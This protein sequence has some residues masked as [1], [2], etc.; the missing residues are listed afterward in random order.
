MIATIT[1]AFASLCISASTLADI[2]LANRYTNV[3]QL[4]LPLKCSLKRDTARTVVPDLLYIEGKTLYLRAKSSGVVP[5]RVVPA[6]AQGRRYAMRK[7][8]TVPMA[9]A[10][11]GLSEST[12][13]RLDKDPRNTNYPGRNASAKVLAAWANLY[14]G[15]RIAVQEV[16]AANRPLLGHSRS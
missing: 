1:A 14:K 5:L 9:A 3:T 11:T 13:K 12:I 8:L 6:A 10:I 15:E 7:T 2:T 4:L 16:R